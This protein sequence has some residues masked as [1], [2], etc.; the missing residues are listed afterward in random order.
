MLFWHGI[1][2]GVDFRGGTLVYVKFSHPP[3]DNAVRSALDRVGLH[4]FRLQT[5]GDKGSN[6]LLID[7]SVQETSEQELD[8]GKIQIINAL[9][10]N[11]QA[12]RDDALSAPVVASPPQIPL[13]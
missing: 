10:T 7:L 4:N 6:E 12:D 8:K 5:L 9:E 3:N 1:P 11:A 2:W 13:P